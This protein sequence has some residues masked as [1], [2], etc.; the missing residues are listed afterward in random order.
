MT[1]MAATPIFKNLLLQNQKAD[2]L[3]TWYVAL[4]MLAGFPRSGKSQWKM[5][6]IQGQGQIR[7]FWDESGKFEI[8]EKVR[9]KSGKFVTT[10]H[11]FECW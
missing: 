6:K 4:G 5:K 11:I 7:E 8:L 1:K 10:C 9:E 3:W 2:D